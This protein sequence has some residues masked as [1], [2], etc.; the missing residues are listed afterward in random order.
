ME[1]PNELLG[2]LLGTG[3]TRIREIR[4]NSGAKVFIEPKH[5]NP[6]KRMRS[7]TI[8]G[9]KACNEEAHRLITLTLQCTDASGVKVAQP[10]GV[11]TGLGG[12]PVGTQP[13]IGSATYAAPA[14]TP[15]QPPPQ[16]TQQ[17]QYAQQQQAQQAQAQAA[18][19]AQQQAAQ[20]QYQQQVQQYQQY[21]QQ[22]EQ[23]EQY[24]QGQ[25]P[26][27]PQQQQPPQQ[28]QYQYAPAAPPQPAMYAP[29]MG[30]P[31]LAPPG[32]AAPY[33]YGGHGA[34]PPTFVS[35]K[36]GSKY[37]TA[38]CRNFGAGMPCKF[39]DNCNFAHGEHELSRA[40]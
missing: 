8:T 29:Q 5:V 9:T 39:G 35:Y 22:Y 1:V 3:G 33:G 11:T 17:Y 6:G 32:M 24:Q 25:Q 26:H 37:K 30:A 2:A 31:P 23:Y 40:R 16:P 12:G 28:P 15:A 21:Q 19:A 27:D 34:L 18:Q 4:T 14:P 38:I 13:E 7:V 36:G 20:A 10:S